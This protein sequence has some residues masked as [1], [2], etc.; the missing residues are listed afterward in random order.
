LELH[1]GL[2][3]S[4]AGVA[5]GL[6]LAFVFTRSLATLLFQVKPLDPMTLIAASG[7]VIVVTLVA[8][9]VPARRASRLDPTV[10]LRHE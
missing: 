10:A 9:Y 1:Q 4:I 8:S 5:L 2:R 3:M 6:G 7:L